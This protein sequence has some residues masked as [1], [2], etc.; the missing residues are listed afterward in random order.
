M[1]SDGLRAGN[2]AKSGHKATAE[3]GMIR[4]LTPGD[5]VRLTDKVRHAEY[6]GMMGTVKKVIKSRNM[7]AVICDNGKRYDAFPE[8]VEVIK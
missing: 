4:V 2:A 1:Q 6:R 8:N 5:K 7:V 3:K